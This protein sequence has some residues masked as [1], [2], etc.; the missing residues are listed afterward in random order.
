MY[1]RPVAT[2]D[3]KRR[4]QDLLQF[5]PQPQ[6]PKGE[7]AI[8]TGLHGSY[9]MKSAKA[10]QRRERQRAAQRLASSGVQVSADLH[11]DAFDEGR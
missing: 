5:G 7:S 10:R 11:L 6:G 2:D 9:E 3:E 8:M 1:R 4:L